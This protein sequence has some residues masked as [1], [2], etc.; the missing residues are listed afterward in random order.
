MCCTLKKYCS[1]FNSFL[2]L[3]PALEIIFLKLKNWTNILDKHTNNFN[4]FNLIT[5]IKLTNFTNWQMY[6]HINL[7]INTKK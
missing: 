5:Y 3:E 4:T 1:M 7:N 2:C 6:I